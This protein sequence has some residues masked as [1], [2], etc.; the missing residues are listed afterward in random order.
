MKLSKIALL[1]FVFLVLCVSNLQAQMKRERYQTVTTYDSAFWTS[2]LYAQSTTHFLEARNLNA[3][4]MHS[5][6]I[7]TSDV[8]QN[9]FGLDTSP[10]VRLGVDYGITDRWQAGFGRSY[11]LNV[12]DLRS[13]Y[14]LLRQKSDGS[15]PLSLAI[16]GDLGIVTERDRKPFKDDLSTLLSA[17]FSRRFNDMWNFQLSPMWAHFS[18]TGQGEVNELFSIG[19]GTQ[20]HLSKRFSLAAEY[21]PVLGDR[22][23]GTKNAFAIGLDIQT[24]G[25]VFQLFLTSSYWQ[26][27]QYVLAQNT[28]Q[29]SAGD[30]RF[31]FNINRVFGL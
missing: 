20:V 24:G 29:F 8:I 3:T 31:G 7:A 15:V 10:N 28:D 17:V 12:V 5:F 1:S 9:L 26:L 16:K 25:H 14:A 6:G 27:E 11:F 30:F 19:L 22:N 13:K 23:T 4:I 21:Y 18:D 2:T